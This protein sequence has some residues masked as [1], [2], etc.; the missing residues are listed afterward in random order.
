MNAKTVFMI[1]LLLGLLSACNTSAPNPTSS[2]GEPYIAPA[3]RLAFDTSVPPTPFPESFNTPPVITDM[4]VNQVVLNR[5][6]EVA[7]AL[8]VQDLA[9]LS[10]YVH[11][12]S[13]LRLTA[14]SYVN[15]TDLVFSAKQVAALPADSQV[16]TW[17]EHA[18]SGEPISFSFPDYYAEFIYDLDFI[19]APRMSL[20]QRLSIGSALDNI[21][22]FY[23]GSMTV[24]FHF[25][26][27]DP[28]YDGIDWRS[29]RL[30]FTEYNGSWYLGG[31]VHDEWTP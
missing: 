28:Q 2:S 20:N 11:P 19:N 14:Y 18:G 30:V 10:T 24:E 17:G 8:K 16:Y 9:A 3:T 21:A 23:P 25:P 6:F 12:V 31:L 13:G 1:I 15:E 22:E 26:G 7:S 5:A 29:L 27:I 4:P